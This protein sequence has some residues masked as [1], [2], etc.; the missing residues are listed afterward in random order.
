MEYLVL[1]QLTLDRPKTEQLFTLV[2]PKFRPLMYESER[3][4]EKENLA[5]EHGEHLHAHP[6]E[7]QIMQVT[8]EIKQVNLNEDLENY[9]YR[10]G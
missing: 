6:L 9:H 5:D 1:F 4:N 8:H 2:F 7:F 3:K 10:Q